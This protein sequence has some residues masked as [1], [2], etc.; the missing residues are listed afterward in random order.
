[1]LPLINARSPPTASP[2]APRA[3]TSFIITLGGAENAVAVW[4]WLSAMAAR[5]DV[6]IVGGC[7]RRGLRGGLLHC[8][9]CAAQEKQEAGKSLPS[10]FPSLASRSML[11]LSPTLTPLQE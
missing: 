9:A 1:M 4:R 2:V 3:A 10:Q 11:L 7:Q 8:C 5:V 6:K